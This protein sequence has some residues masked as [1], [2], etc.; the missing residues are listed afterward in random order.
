MS[1]I[2]ARWTPFVAAL[3]SLAA[4]VFVF[5]QNLRVAVLWDLGYLL[6]TSWRIDCGQMPYRDFPLSHAPLTFLTQAALIELFGRAYLAVKLYA[7]TAGALSAWLGWLIVRRLVASRWLAVGLTAP[8]IFLNTQGVY[9]HPIYDTDCALAVLFALWLLIGLAQ[10]TNTGWLRSGFT[11]AA[12]MA[13][14][15]YKQNIGLPFA[16]VAG[17]VALV[18]LFKQ[19]ERGKGI[20]LLGGMLVASIAAVAT[21]AASFGLGNYIHWTVA[22]AVQRR[23]PGLQL[24]VAIYET[25]IGYWPLLVMLLGWMVL[26]VRAGRGLRVNPLAW[27][28]TPKTTADSSISHSTQGVACL[29]QHD[30]SK[31]AYTFPKHIS[32]ALGGLLMAT[33]LLWTAWLVVTSEDADAMTDAL[34]ALWPLL[35]ALAAIAAMVN[36]RCGVTLERMIPFVILAAIHGTFLSQQLWG[37]TYAIWPLLV[38]MVAGW[39]G[40]LPDGARWLQPAV[41]G[42]FA[43]VLLICGGMYATSLE[44]LSYVDIPEGAA[45]GSRVTAL[46]GMRTPGEYLSNLDEL[47]HWTDANIPQGDALLVIPGEDPFYYATGR[48]PRFP[49]TLMDPAT[50]P[51]SA[52]ELM[53]E[54]ARRGVRWV[55]VK[56]ELQAR[57][58]PM[59]ERE[60]TLRLVEQEY[61]AV[62]ELRGYR[63]WR[64]I[65]RN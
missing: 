38:V 29:P 62:K 2:S 19:D 20:G 11:G 42:V 9:P 33:P 4:A 23:M 32:S 44:R 8:L 45:A 47:I 6:D 36:L 40:G 60:A 49:V 25:P 10:K 18:M 7:A 1:G 13:P 16:F 61:E 26:N 22:F 54:A 57:E 34:L 35:L 17:V 48:V 58:N 21:I 56:T 46:S 64:R 15:F 63:V 28:P 65:I 3:F 39:V 12:V 53:R 43:T 52:E 5:R 37:S 24:I 14:I 31:N 55:I 41:G 51:Y 50:D 30:S 27:S 59:P